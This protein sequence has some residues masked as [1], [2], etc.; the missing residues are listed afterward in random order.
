MVTVSFPGMNI[1]EFRLNPIAVSFGNGFS[2]YWY[3]IITAVAIVVSLGY[4][5]WKSKKYGVT[6]DNLLDLTVF[7]VI[8]SLIGARISY[9][10]TSP[11]EFKS[12]L[13]VISIWDGRLSLYGAMISGAATI[14]VICKIKKMSTLHVLDLAALTLLLGQV[15]GVWGGFLNGTA[16]GIPV[17]DNN[18]LYLFRMGIFPHSFE[19]IKGTAYVHPI[20]LYDF[21]LNALGFVLISIFSRKKKFDGQT[22]LMY[23]TWYGFGR[24]FTEG[25]RTDSLYIGVFRSS[26]VMSFICFVLGTVTLIFMLAK[27]YRKVKDSQEYIPSYKKSSNSE[28]MFD[29]DEDDDDYTPSFNFGR[30]DGISKKASD[31]P[32]NTEKNEGNNNGTDN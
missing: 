20:F 17:A 25:L 24:M 14:A 13:D 1:G 4:L 6:F 19:D 29:H 9:I 10:I 28:F 2:I 12:F 5:W 11:G 23:L 3:G 26:Q 27:S 22:V 30:N 31:E 16:Y 15:V 8:F 21:I 32:R 7:T 18:L